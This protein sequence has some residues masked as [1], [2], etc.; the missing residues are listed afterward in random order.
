MGKSVL[1]IDDEELIRFN[2]VS[3][4]EDEAFDVIE[5]G[6]AEEALQILKE[7]N[8]DVSIVDQRLPGMDG[9]SFILQASQISP[10]MRFVIHTGSLEY[11]IPSRLRNLGINEEHIL[12]KPLYDMNL[13]VER[14]SRLT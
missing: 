8:P 12:H 3:Y 6:S 9:N 5:A 1:V 11:E 14:I 4:L 7:H 10:H 13:L 2:L